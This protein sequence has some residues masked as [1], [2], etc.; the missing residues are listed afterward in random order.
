MV[1]GQDA[2]ALQKIIHNA[3]Q[4]QNGK[5]K[6]ILLDTV[7]GAGISCVEAIENNHCIGVPGSLE[8]QCL[9]ELKI[10]REQLQKGLG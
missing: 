1:C 5:P 2:A 6:M 7:K 3:L 4:N 9:E 10:S 8:E